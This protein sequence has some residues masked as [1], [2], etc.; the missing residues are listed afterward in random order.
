MSNGFDIVSGLAVERE[1]SGGIFLKFKFQGEV[2]V[3]FN[4]DKS[5]L[6]TKKM[7]KK[8]QKEMKNKL[9]SK[10]GTSMGAK[11]E[12]NHDRLQENRKRTQIKD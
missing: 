9:Y 12:K 10:S 8:A 4:S 5:K 7:R 3:E 6:S 2:R 11:M 1:F